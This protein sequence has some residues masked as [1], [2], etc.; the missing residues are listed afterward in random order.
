MEY[1]KVIVLKDGRECILRSA[2]AAD[3]KEVLDVFIRTHGQT[4]FLST[5]PD[6]IHFTAESEAVFLVKKAAAPRE[7]ELLTA[8]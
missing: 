6:E 3:A 1:R 4:E 7:I 2:A 8:G 5:Y